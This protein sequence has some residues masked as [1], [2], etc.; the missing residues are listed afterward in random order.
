MIEEIF[1]IVISRDDRT[2]N[3]LPSVIEANTTSCREQHPL[4]R[5]NRLNEAEIESFLAAHFEAAVLKAFKSLKP[6]AYKADIGR[7]CLLLHFGGLY[8]DLSLRL[9][10]PAEIPAGKAMLCFRDAVGSGTGLWTVSNGL[11][12]ATAGRE[13]F[14]SAIAMIASNVEQRY[15][16]CSPLHPTGPALFGRAIAHVDRERDIEVGEF[17]NLTGNANPNNFGCLDGS[18]RLLALR[19][20]TGHLSELGLQGTNHYA[21]MWSLGRIYGEPMRYVHSDP[22]LRVIDETSR[23]IDGIAFAQNNNGYLVFGPFVALEA[24]RYRA[25]YTFAEKAIPV[26]VTIDVVVGPVVVATRQCGDEDRLSAS[27]DFTVPES[28]PLVQVRLFLAGGG[29]GLVL[30]LLIESCDPFGMGPGTVAV[31]HR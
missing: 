31:R 1:Q 6:Y 10:H 26:G 7:Y 5:Y 30:D 15:Y 21:E 14:R 8:V 4:A 25:A 24:G 9:L 29:S 27:I 12:A 11:I 20:K 18:G 17:K 19:M 13:E 16:G 22:S 23:T 28:F 3:S 2:K